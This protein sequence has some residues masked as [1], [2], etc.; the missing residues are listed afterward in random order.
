MT[1]GADGPN[2]DPVGRLVAH[3]GARPAEAV[4]TGLGVSS[5]LGLLMLVPLL[6]GGYVDADK[7]PLTQASA[8]I[9]VE[10]AAG[11]VALIATAFRCGDMA[12]WRVA[13]I[14]ALVAAIAYFASAPGLT[15]WPLVACRIAS[16]AG[17]GILG[18]AVNASVA[19]AAD[20][21]RL[22]ATALICYGAASTAFLYLIPVL[23]IR[24][25]YWF[26][27]GTVG[28]LFLST[29]AAASAL[30]KST[31][32]AGIQGKISLRLDNQSHGRQIVG[33]IG[34]YLLMWIAFSMVW[35][36]AERKA[37]SIGMSA[38]ETGLA[39]SA[40]N[41]IGMSG[42][43]AVTWLGDRFGRSIPIVVGGAVLAASFYA[44]GVATAPLE[45]WVAIIAYGVAYFFLLPYILGHAAELDSLGRVAMMASAVPWISHLVSPLLG[46]LVLVR[47]GA[48]GTMAAVTAGTA[49]VATAVLAVTTANRRA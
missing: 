10:V 43:L 27:F 34:G 31:L 37:A 35:I 15:F 19:R 40:C 6:V 16:G 8:L 2:T 14:G 39:L 49:I 17:V 38:D 22:Y 4:A 33:L 5:T 44:I 23:C 42:S 21:E 1:L 28:A 7:L 32:N 13:R 48:F 3:L 25:G 29:A 26:L 20:P 36:F 12:I 45:Y 47:F 24:F 11:L 46:A 30:N 41:L 9:T 18:A